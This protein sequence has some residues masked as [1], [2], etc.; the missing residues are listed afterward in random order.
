MITELTLVNWCQHSHRVLEFGPGITAL[1][2]PNG[3]GKSNIQAAVKWLWT[4]LNPN[5]G[6]KQENIYQLA[7]PHERAN[8]RMK[9]TKRGHNFELYRSL[10]PDTDQATLQYDG[11]LAAAGETKVTAK[12]A[13]LYGLDPKLVDRFMLVAQEDIFGFLAEQPE[14]RLKLFQQLFDTTH[15]ARCIKAIADHDSKLQVPAETQGNLDTLLLNLQQKQAELAQA[16]QQLA[17]VDSIADFATAQSADQKIVDAYAGYLAATGQQDA[18]AMEISQ[19]TAAIFPDKSSLIELRSAALSLENMITAERQNVDAIRAAIINLRNYQQV[20]EQRQQWQDRVAVLERS[21]TPEPTVDAEP[22]APKPPE[23]NPRVAELGNAIAAITAEILKDQ[24]YVSQFRL[25]GIAECPT[26]RTPTTNIADTVSKVE[27][28]IPGKSQQLATLQAELTELRAV[29][30]QAAD[31]YLA[32]TT[33]YQQARAKRVQQQQAHAAWSQA[34]AVRESEL[35]TLRTQLQSPQTL[36]PVD[37]NAVEWQSKIKTYDEASVMLTQVRAK[38]STIEERVA[39]SE[40]SIAAKQEQLQ[41]LTQRWLNAPKPEEAQAAATR[42]MQRTSQQ[43]LHVTCS[44]RV[45]GLR[46]QVEQLLAESQRMSQRIAEANRMRNWIQEGTEVQ[47]ALKQSQKIVLQT[48]LQR[49]EGELNDL[50]RI[51]DAPFTVMA[52]DSL[53]FSALFHDGRRQGA[54]RLSGG[55]KTLLAWLFRIA[56]AVQFAENL[57]VLFLDEP[58]AYLDKK[59]IAAFAPV[60]DRL[61][62][63]LAD[64]GLQVIIVTHEEELAPLFDHVISL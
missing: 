64:R 39:K 35:K 4:G 33:T 17:V 36:T 62:G 46:P 63:I 61:R 24:S 51:C 45:A 22:E 60:F 41:A 26:C 12:L 6:T 18:L 37:G 56:A 5:F 40:G 25:T 55:Q 43:Q 59:A 3:S 47:E 11:V 30:Q 8:A 52:D 19:L 2:G 49:A 27:A 57:D 58:T 20:L 9:M 14:V 28:G 1:I 15:A 13:E 10:R 38:I 31:Q 34:N 48:R 53:N 44:T 16:E 42:I 50:L 7:P 21:G 23:T 54:R 32:A 29:A